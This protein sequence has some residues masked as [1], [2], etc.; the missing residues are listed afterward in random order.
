[1]TEVIISESARLRIVGIIEYYHEI[2]YPKS[3]IKIAEDILEVIEML[4]SQP[5]IGSIEEYLR[6]LN[7][8]HRSFPT[9]N[10]KIIYKFVDDN[11]I[12]ITDVFD[13]RRHPRRMKG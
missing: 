4:S 3:G 8:G 6:H 12:L 7:A 13:C 9:G 5:H 1:M 10:Y 11:T 2:G